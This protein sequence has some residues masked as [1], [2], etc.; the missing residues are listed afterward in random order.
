[1]AKKANSIHLISLDQVKPEQVQWLW[2]G[3]VPLGKITILQ[4]DPGLGKSTLALDIASRTT[5]NDRMPDDSVSDL[6]E[7]ADVV[8]L[9]AEDGLADTICP[10]LDALGAD[11]QRIS[12]PQEHWRIPIDADLIG[13][14]LRERNAKLLVVDPLT[15]FLDSSVNSWNNQHVRRALTPLAEVAQQTGAAILIVDHLNKRSGIAAIQRG[16]GSIGFNAAARSVLLAGKHPEESEKV[17]LASVK[18]NLGRPPASLAYRMAE[19]ENKAVRIEWLGEC[20]YGA[21]DLVNMSFE[22][23]NGRKLEAAVEFLKAKLSQNTVLSSVVEKE[24]ASQG[25]SERTLRRAKRQL[26][27]KSMPIGLQGEWVLSLPM[28]QILSPG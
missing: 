23:G 15:A 18:S 27:V 14:A 17:V 13:E 11:R 10:R 4:G 9:S 2:P 6:R 19:A 3:R 28:R 12:V 26:G 25:I 22:A 7:V 21:D 24:A 1:M 8:L 20:P 5:R 16:S